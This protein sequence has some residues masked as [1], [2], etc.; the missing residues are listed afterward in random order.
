MKR[1]PVLL[2][3]ASA[4]GLAALWL[5]ASANTLPR[6]NPASAHDADEQGH[7]DHGDDHGTPG[8]IELSAEQIASSR[9]EVSPAAAC[10]MRQ[11]LTVPG[12]VVPDAD[13][14]GR[15]PAKVVGTVA[16]LRKRLG[17][18]TSKDEIVAVLDS[19]EVADARSDF[20]AAVLNFDLQKTLFERQAALYERQITAEQQYLRSQ[21]DFR[22]AELKVSIARQKLIALGLGDNEIA[23]LSSRQGA[24]LRQ[25]EVRAPLA[26]QIIERR[27]DLGAP[28]GRE[29]QE[30]EIY[31]IADLSSLWVELA[32][33]TSE[34]SRI[35]VSQP[36]EISTTNASAQAEAKI[37]FISPILNA[38][39]RS[40][41]VI[42]TLDNAARTWRPGS[43][44]T[45]KVTTSQEAAPLCVPAGAL[46]TIEGQ[47]QVFVRTDSGF[48]KREVVIGRRDEKN[49]EVVFGL[50]PG[51]HVAA[52]NTF[53]LKAQ[54]AKGEAGHGHE[55]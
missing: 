7:G 24:S 23:A 12:T 53:V 1:I 55:H 37:V 30:N 51:E 47:Q 54:L 35:A 33:P 21:T 43:F 39:T 36:V 9:I 4:A 8:N 50:D 45:A 18:D 29:G 17:D 31:V 34:L 52:T 20:M 14:V 40:A 48:E 46:Q 26:G 25:F 42:A 3:V 49:A 19:R 27:V 28:V 41:R 2:G 44:V 10:V 32:V 16:E 13:R 11:L 22:D 38:D 5:Y 15:V 6:P